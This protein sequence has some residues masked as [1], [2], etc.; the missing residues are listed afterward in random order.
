MHVTIHKVMTLRTELIN[1]R[2]LLDNMTQPIQSALVAQPQTLVTGDFPLYNLPS[3]SN[4]QQTEIQ[5][6]FQQ[7][8]QQQQFVHG[9]GNVITNESDL[10]ALAWELLNENMATN[11]PTPPQTQQ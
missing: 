4:I 11:G 1:M 3:S 7:E 10:Q 6:A 2:T 5:W 9:G 8:E